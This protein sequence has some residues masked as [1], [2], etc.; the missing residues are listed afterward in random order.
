MAFICCAG[1]YLSDS[2]PSKTCEFAPLGSTQ[3]QPTEDF[4]YPHVIGKVI[5]LN[6]GRLWIAGGAETGGY[7]FTTPVYKDLLLLFLFSGAFAY[8]ICRY[9]SINFW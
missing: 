1:V 9:E 2:T 4:K 3:W 8:E 5:A 7:I 6:D